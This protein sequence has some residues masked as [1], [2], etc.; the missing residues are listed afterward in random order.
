MLFR[1]KINQPHVV[2]EHFD[3]EVIAIN[4]ETGS[5]YS[6]E[7]SAAAIWALLSTG[8]TLPEI[9]TEVNA[10]YNGEPA[11]MA[12]AVQQFIDDLQRTQLIVAYANGHDAAHS[13]GFA[14]I[15]P[16]DEK[17]H[18]DLPL[19]CEYNDMQDLLLLDPI[20]EVD[21]Q[22]WPQKTGLN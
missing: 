21:A 5:Y 1:F 19:L 6:M 9:L 20:H 12:Q 10:R 22:G 7:K 16:S 2:A 3:N 11:L 17:I 8:A 13:A 18:F 14:P 4:L 15:P